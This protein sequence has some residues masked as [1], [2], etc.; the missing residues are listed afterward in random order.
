MLMIFIIEVGYLG[1]WHIRTFV[2]DAPRSLNLDNTKKWPSLSKYL[3]RNTV[4][5]NSWDGDICYIMKYLYI[6]IQGLTL[7]IAKRCVCYKCLCVT[8]SVNSENGT[9]PHTY[10][11]VSLI[12]IWRTFSTSLSCSQLMKVYIGKCTKPIKWGTDNTL[13]SKGYRDE[14]N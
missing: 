1:L 12:L 6:Y 13:I 3:W 2:I 10:S 11:D 14:N 8:S 5:H 4:F 7:S 9:D